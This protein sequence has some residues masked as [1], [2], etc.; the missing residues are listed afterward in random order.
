MRVLRALTQ[1]RTHSRTHF[2]CF[3]PQYTACTRIRVFSVGP[4]QNVNSCAIHHHSHI[5]PTTF[6]MMSIFAGR[7]CEVS[8]QFVQMRTLVASCPGVTLDMTSGSSKSTLDTQSATSWISSVFRITNFF[9]PNNS[10]I[11]STTAKKTIVC[12]SLCEGNRR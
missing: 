5:S 1:A 10:I 11:C 9:G 2:I 7:L 6:I 4:I 3:L 8:L 12:K